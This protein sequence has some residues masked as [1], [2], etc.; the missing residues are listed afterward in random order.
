[1]SIQLPP[2]RLSRSQI[3]INALPIDHNY[4]SSGGP[5]TGKTLLALLRAKKVLEGI[6]KKEN[7]ESRVLFIVY[8]RPL[9]NYLRNNIHKI[10]MMKYHATTYHSWLYGRIYNCN[11][12]DVQNGEYK[13]DWEKVAI[14]LKGD[15]NPNLDHVILDEAQDLPRSLVETLT[16]ISSNFTIF[17]DDNQ[18]ISGE[19]DLLTFDD[20]KR[21]IGDPYKTFPLLENHRNS[22][23]IVDFSQLFLKPGDI[24]PEALNKGGRKPVV[25]IYNNTEAYAKRIVAYSANNPD[26]NVAVVMSNPTNRDLFYNE[27]IN[28]GGKADQYI[29]SRKTPDFDPDSK[30]IKVFTYKTHK[31]LEFDAVFLPELDAEYFNNETEQIRNQFMVAVT[32]AKERLFIGTKNYQYSASFVLQKIKEN[33]DLVDISSISQD[34]SLSEIVNKRSEPPAFDASESFD[35]DI[36]F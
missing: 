13:Y 26:Q 31:G 16:E 5:G 21:I 8:N 2:D 3:L 35:D 12:K 7:R 22:Q 14:N 28:S 4:V 19:S 17:I 15:R 18:A 10:G 34:A 25:E 30:V 6:A 1:M 11:V 33:E 9:Q 24:A 32:R 36:P 20:A 23:A 27:I 29:D